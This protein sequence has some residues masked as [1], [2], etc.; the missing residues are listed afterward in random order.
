MWVLLSLERQEQVLLSMLLSLE[1]QEQLLLSL[2]L[3]V[4]LSLGVELLHRGRSTVTCEK[5]QTMSDQFWH[6][7]NPFWSMSEQFCI[8]LAG[9][10]P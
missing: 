4:L 10:A 7:P 2:L 3:S 1:R 9:I 6:T 8:S 5:I